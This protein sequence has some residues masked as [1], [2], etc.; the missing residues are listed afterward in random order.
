MLFFLQIQQYNCI[1]KLSIDCYPLIRY[2]TNNHTRSLR[3]LQ[4]LIYSKDCSLQ[5]LQQDR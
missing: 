5:I 2:L 4:C 3:L 1:M